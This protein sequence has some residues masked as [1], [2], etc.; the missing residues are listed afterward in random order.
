MLKIRLKRLGRKKQA[1][2]R[3]ILIDSRKKREGRALKEIGYY[4]PLDKK[5]KINIE[6]IKNYMKHGAQM[7]KR[8]EKIL[9]KK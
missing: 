5:I 2:Y 1:F 9:K 7:T 8:I 4:S 6:M 3:V